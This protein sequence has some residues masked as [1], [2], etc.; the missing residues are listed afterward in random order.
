MSYRNYNIIA[1]LGPSSDKKSM[2]ERMVHAGVN[3]FRLNTSHL[4]FVQ[5]SSWLEKLHPFLESSGLVLVIDLQGSKWRLGNFH[6]FELKQDQEVDLILAAEAKLPNVLPVPHPDFFQAAILT[7]TSISSQSNKCIT[8]NDAKITLQMDSASNDKVTAK[9]IQ[10]G[11]ISPRKGI[12]LVGSDYRKEDL[13]IFDEQVM[14][15]TRNSLHI[16][17]AISYVK[18][19]TEMA[20]YHSLLGPSAYLIAK[21]E[22]QSAINDAVKIAS[23][24]NELWLCRG[25]LGAELGMKRLAGLVSRFGGNIPAMTTPVLMAGQILEHMT[26]NAT[27]TRS[28]ICYLYDTLKRGYKGVVLSDETAIGRY[29]VESCQAAAIFLL[30]DPL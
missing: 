21:L 16:R 27:P 25:D 24:A 3:G 28:E 2:W 5:L 13:C 11:L 23:H 17:Y 6:P 26:E 29:P 12:V 19:A 8:L 14:L 15:A 1:T 10:N 18:D 30:D 4:T 20:N 9:V 7:I 22:R